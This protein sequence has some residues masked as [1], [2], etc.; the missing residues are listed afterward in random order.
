MVGEIMDELV[1]ICIPV[2]NGEKY[3]GETLK[4]LVI[5]SY[6]NIQIIVSDNCSDDNTNEIVEEIKKTDSR[7]KYYRNS[8]N[9]GYVNNILNAVT[10]ATSEIIT[11]YHADDIYDQHIIE[12]ELYILQNYPKLGAVFSAAYDFKDGNINNSHY[13]KIYKKLKRTEVYIPESNIFFGNKEEYL[14]I[15]A[16]YGN[17]FTCPSLMVYKSIYLNLGGYTDRYPS[18]EDF[19]L[20]LR[21][22]DDGYNIAMLSKPLMYYRHS[23]E[24]GSNFFANKPELPMMYQLFIDYFNLN[25]TYFTQLDLIDKTNMLISKGYCKASLCAFGQS[26]ADYKFFLAKSKEYYLFPLLSKYG[27]FQR[28][29]IVY[30]YIKKKLLCIRD[31]YN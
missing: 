31:R 29:S 21:I 22:L 28:Y 9:I 26:N 16:E 4:S 7:I 10:K 5:Q 3:I 27:L 2:F 25:E 19:D 15:F 13:N 12:E 11:I 6:K 8:S 24:Q 1:T 17:I 20:W 18:N 14:K 23:V 30:L